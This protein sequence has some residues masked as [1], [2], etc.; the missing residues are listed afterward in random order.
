MEAGA[1]QI[2]SIPVT[3]IA[4]IGVRNSLGTSP[5]IY[6]QNLSVTPVKYGRGHPAQSVPR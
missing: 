5:E 4:L 3:G 2:D 1:T 6:W